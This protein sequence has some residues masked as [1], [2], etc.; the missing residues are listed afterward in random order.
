[1]KKYSIILFGLLFLSVNTA[2]SQR[3]VRGSVF[4]EK[5][6]TDTPVETTNSK[7]ATRRFEDTI[8]VGNSTVKLPQQQST[9]TNTTDEF[10]KA[11]TLFNNQK[12]VDAGEKFNQLATLL[13]ADDPLIY[14]VQFMQGECAS[15][16]GQLDKAEKILTMLS[17]KKNI[18]PGVMERA[19]VRLG[20]VFCGLGKTDQATK[21]FA[22]FRQE[23]PASQYNAVANCDSVK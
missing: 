1:M 11:T 22:R 8:A 23:F 15:V 20:H 21:A 4:P 19:L 13:K 5:Q 3:P 12:Y 10:E 2:F 16:L 6:K 18:P 7:V 17:T 9:A 14:E